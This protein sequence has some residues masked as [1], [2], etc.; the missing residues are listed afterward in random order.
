MSFAP[1]PD[2]PRYT[3]CSDGTLYGWRYAKPLKPKLTRWGYHEVTLADRGRTRTV[4]VHTLVL[5]AF[6]GPRP[7]GME[8]AHMDGNSI[9]NDV[10][11]LAW[12]TH[13]ENIA[14]KATHGTKVQGERFWSARLN[15]DKVRDIRRRYA[16]GESAHSMAA[17]F[18][19]SRGSVWRAATG[20][21]WK[22]VA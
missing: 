10:G 9:N 20:Q 16:D 5:D 22:H 1:V 18:G 11:N 15:V 4:K 2:F 6:V 12:V 17:E 7:T 3:I 19:V 14:H 21:S 8:A 13:A